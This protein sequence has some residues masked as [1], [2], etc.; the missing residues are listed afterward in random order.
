MG[1]FAAL[2]NR[3]YPDR[4]LYLFDTFS[5]FDERDLSINEV[6][7]GFGKGLT[8]TNEE[9]SVLKCLHQEKIVVKKGYVPRTFS[10]LENERFAFVSLDMDLYK[11]QLAGMEFFI[12]RMSKGG[13]ILVH[14]YYNPKFPTLKQAVA[15]VAERFDMVSF[16]IGDNWSIAIMAK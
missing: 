7:T 13:V 1:D 11:P 5:G 2:I 3:F 4:T 15:Q 10:G 6:E 16:P 14:D 9:I 12:P 8:F